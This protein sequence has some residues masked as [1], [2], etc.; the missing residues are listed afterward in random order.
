MLSKLLIQIH[1]WRSTG[2]IKSAKEFYDKYSHVDE[3]FFGVR[4]F[5]DGNRLLI[6]RS[7]Q[8]NLILDKDTGNIILKK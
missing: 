7:L 8:Q 5:I 3:S 4:S 2:D 1:I 6:R